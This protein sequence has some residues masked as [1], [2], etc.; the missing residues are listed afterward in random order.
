M[1]PG[2]KVSIL[3]SVLIPIIVALVV[4]S[5]HAKSDYLKKF[6]WQNRLLVIFAPRDINSN[7][8]LQKEI[9]AKSYYGSLERQ[10]RIIEVVVSMPVKVD[11]RAD[12]TLE[13]SKLRQE[14]GVTK[15][16]FSVVLIGKD[17]SEKGR[18]SEPLGSSHL[19]QIIDKMPMRMDEM[20]ER[21]D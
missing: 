7:L 9:I 21:S 3:K 17:G 10:I 2:D 19:F 5:N 13:G 11:G 8:S 12:V 6:L 14:Y 16:Q 4:L 15:D 20:R 1:L 18:W